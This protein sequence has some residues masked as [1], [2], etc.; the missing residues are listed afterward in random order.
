MIRSLA[1]ISIV[2]RWT[3]DNVSVLNPATI[4]RTFHDNAGEVS[5]VDPGIAWLAEAII[6][7]LPID[8]V[9]PDGENLNENF[10]VSVKLG[11]V[12]GTLKSIFLAR[13]V[14]KENILLRLI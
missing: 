8:R 11:E 10:I 2:C 4:A 5:T 7:S 9:K 12:L 13:A 14:K 1:H 6:R 3:E